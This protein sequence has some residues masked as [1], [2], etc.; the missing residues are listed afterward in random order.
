MR[1]FFG[2]VADSAAA[3]QAMLHP[4]NSRTLQERR[5][6]APRRPRFTEPGLFVCVREWR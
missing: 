3:F 5:G 4:R 1:P 2:R 6:A